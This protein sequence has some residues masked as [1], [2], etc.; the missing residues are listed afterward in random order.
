MVDKVCS[1]KEIRE[2]LDKMKK[3]MSQFIV[4]ISV[5]TLCTI[6]TLAATFKDVAQTHWAYTNI[7]DMQKR[8]I[9]LLNSSGEFFPNAPMNFFEIAD[10]LAK[11]TGYVD[12]NMSPTIDPTFKQQII[13]N[14]AVQKPVLA[15]YE[16]NFT[17]WDKRYNEQI[18]YLLGRGYL[19]K[20]ELDQFITRGTDQREIKKIVTKQQLAVFIVR[21]L[22]KEATAKETYSVADF[23]DESLILQTSKPH[24]GYLKAVGLVN[25][26][27]KG[28]FNPNTHV[29]RALCAKMVS[30]ALKYKQTPTPEPAPAS[31]PVPTGSGNFLKVKKIIEKSW[32]I[33]EQ[34]GKTDYYAIKDTTK[35]TDLSG[36]E[37]EIANIP[38]ETQA[39]IVIGT[40]NNIKYITNMQLQVVINGTAPSSDAALVSG[41]VT[42]VG[43]N[44]DLS[45]MLA[46]ESTKNYFVDANCIVMLGQ[47]RATIGEVKIGDS[48]RA[49]IQA[50]AITR[51]DILT[52]M[53]GN[54]TSDLTDGEITAKSLRLEGYGLSIKQGTRTTNLVIDKKVAVTRNNRQVTFEDLKI[55]DKI[56]IIKQETSI[57]EIKATGTRSTAEGQISAIYIAAVPQVTLKTKD[58]VQTFIISEMTEIYDNNSRSE[59]AFRDLR[60]GNNVELLIESKEVVS[61]VIG[62]N[63][64][65]VRYAG[66][67][68]AV[69]E[70]IEYIDVL[71]DYDPLTES[72]RVIKRIKTPVEMPVEL[73]GKLEHRAIF[74][75]GMDVV[76]TYQYLDDV[77]PEKIL[78]IR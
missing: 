6:S 60:L 4:L 5:F 61:L 40:E 34:N 64:T 66:V 24:V 17:S 19:Q 55:G 18:A 9:M 25:A 75:V 57:V 51:L 7:A 27:A 43:A 53:P 21:V 73:R 47:Q 3:K 69:G 13:N 42:R 14:S 78:I 32:I 63:T 49:T 44:G 50:S 74:D 22:G 8:G 58:G 29:T 36:K 33:L 52:A 65:G 48:V 72:S 59:V 46:D 70:R 77:T 26:D 15:V 31:T 30:D 11:A 68:H 39:T 71:V 76:I 23:A 12:V 54:T 16:N 37:V 45:I 41:T 38:L 2:G 67:I 35:V 10:V 20:Q 28:F 1:H 56:K 62:R